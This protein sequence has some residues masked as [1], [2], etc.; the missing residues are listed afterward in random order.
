MVELLV[1]MA[2]TAILMMTLFSLVGQSTTSYTQTQRA[3]NTLSQAR[4][5]MQFFDREISTRLPGT[6][7]IHETGNASGGPADS[8]KIA[9]IRAISIDEELNATPGDIGTSIYYVGFSEDKANRSSPKLFRKTYNPAE[10]QTLLETGTN[11]PFPSTSP[12]TDEPLIPN[13]L[14]FQATPKFS[15]A[16][17]ALKDWS[18]TS[19]APPSL[20]EVSITFIDDSSAQRYR[21]EADWNRLA[22]SP[23]D[24]E[25]QIIRTFTRNIAIAK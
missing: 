14:N 3:V 10:T 5:F 22:T 24:N 16:G 19:S 1:A 8:A 2:I 7:L 23:R 18:T 6:S 20:I 15:D 9:F 21:T 25:R 11:P 12:T 4:A 13:I 17:G